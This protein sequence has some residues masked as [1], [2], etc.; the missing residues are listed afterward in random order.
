MKVVMR[1]FS[2]GL[3]AVT[4]INTLARLYCGPDRRNSLRRGWP[5]AQRTVRS[6]LVVGLPPAFH[7]H[8][9]LP[10]RIKQLAIQQFIT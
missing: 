6:N 7:E 1:W 9:R 2:S 4:A 5:I 10:E 8:L 3:L